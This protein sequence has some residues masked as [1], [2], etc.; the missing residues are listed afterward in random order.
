M[1]SALAAADARQWGADGTARRIRKD[2][3]LTQAD[4]ADEIGVTAA[5][6]AAWE[7]GKRTPSGTAARRY[8]ELLRR[9]AGR[10]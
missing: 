7:T 2:A 4:I 3:H 1:A 5:A 9:L 10:D 6:V 8:G